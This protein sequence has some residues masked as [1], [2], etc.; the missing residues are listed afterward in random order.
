MGCVK[1][2]VPVCQVEGLGFVGEVWA[3]GRHREASADRGPRA[4]Q[5]LGVREMRGVSRED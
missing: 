4:L 1:S 5:P 2:E 3:G